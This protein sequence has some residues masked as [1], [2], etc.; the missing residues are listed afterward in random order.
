MTDISE[1]KRV[2]EELRLHKE[3]LEKLVTERTA[4]LQQAN[5]QLR[6]AKEE[7]EAV[8]QAAPLAIG[9]FDAEGRV[10]TAN[11]ANE[12]VFGWPLAEMQGRVDPS[13]PPDDPAGIREHAAAG[14]PGESLVGVELQQQRRD[15][16]LFD[17]R[18]SA[19]PSTEPGGQ[20]AG[21]RGPGAKTLPSGNGL[22]RPCR[23]RSGCWRA[24]SKA[25]W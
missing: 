1:L 17:V 21:F 9:V 12:R 7:L 19:A 6:Q 15:G 8:F 25:W 20:A 14:A 24:W 2:Q 23:P 3:D 22:P 10:V 11:P 13:I 4:K 5:E 18:L 16:S